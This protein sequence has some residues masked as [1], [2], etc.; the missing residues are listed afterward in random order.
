M[1]TEEKE[2]G[3]SLAVAAFQPQ[4]SRERKKSRIFAFFFFWRMIAAKVFECFNGILL[5]LP[6]SGLFY[7]FSESL[8]DWVIYLAL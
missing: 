2:N 7:A 3:V 5:S 4:D 8:A 1:M 6:N